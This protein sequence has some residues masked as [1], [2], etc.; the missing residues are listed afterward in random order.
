MCG[1]SISFLKSSWDSKINYHNTETFISSQIMFY[2][3][4]P[5]KNNYTFQCIRLKQFSNQYLTIIIH[6]INLFQSSQINK[7]VFRNNP[8]CFLRLLMMQ[9]MSTHIFELFSTASL[10]G[11]APFILWLQM[12]PESVL[13]D[14]VINFLS[15]H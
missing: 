15:Q 5:G 13:H 14:N 3:H 12:F 9:H 10:Q 6:I 8:T 1:H 2:F 4:C 11:F 7:L